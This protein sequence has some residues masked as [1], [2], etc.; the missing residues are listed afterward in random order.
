MK[1]TFD[2]TYI[3]RWA[4]SIGGTA[5]ATAKILEALGCSG[6]KADKIAQGKYKSVPPLLE[7]MALCELVNEPMDVLFPP[8][9]KTRTAS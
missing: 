7:Q 3:V 4:A 1:R 8:A 6:T 5:K 9:K 2:Q